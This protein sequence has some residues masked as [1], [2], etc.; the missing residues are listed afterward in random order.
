MTL[1]EQWGKGELPEGKY[2]I[3]LNWGDEIIMAD[4]CGGLFEL[5]EFMLKAIVVNSI[6]G[7][8]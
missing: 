6:F 8:R 1:T 5:D 3:K 4:Y 2:W 7:N